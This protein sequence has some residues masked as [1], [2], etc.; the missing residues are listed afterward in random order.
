MKNRIYNTNSF[1]GLLVSLYGNSDLGRPVRLRAKS[2]VS[3]LGRFYHLTHIG[4]LLSALTFSLGI[5][6]RNLRITARNKKSTAV[7][8]VIY[9]DLLALTLTV[10]CFIPL[11]FWVLWWIDTST[12]VT[13]SSYVGEDTISL[14]FNLCMHGFPTAFLLVEFFGAEFLGRHLHYK[15]LFVF[16]LL[17]VGV[18]YIFYGR[19]GSWPYGIVEVFTG[20]K[21]IVFFVVCFFFI[22]VLY[23]VLT[24][25]H[26]FVSQ[27]AFLKRD[28]GKHND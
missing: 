9:I 11:I 2:L 10:E 7:L 21:R 5:I 6:C 4:L 15:I 1:F 26:Y 24:H 3:F 12:V 20:V 28:K 14:F 25:M 18:M 27:R 17:Y 23:Y 19:T 22:C 13:P 8:Q 16:F